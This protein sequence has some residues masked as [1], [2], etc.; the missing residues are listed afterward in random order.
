MLVHLDIRRVGK[1]GDR[2]ADWKC[3]DC[4]KVASMK[5]LDKD[6]Y[7]GPAK[8]TDDQRLLDAIEG[9]DDACD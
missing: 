3:L 2:N 4:G 8:K 6:N 1:I 9:K 5:E 7:C